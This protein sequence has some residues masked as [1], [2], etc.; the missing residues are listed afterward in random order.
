MTYSGWD[1]MGPRTT[2]GHKGGNYIGYNRTEKKTLVWYTFL[3]FSLT[4]YEGPP[5]TYMY[6]PT[7]GIW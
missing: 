7:R 4:M 6:K 1:A 5:F 2:R 3:D